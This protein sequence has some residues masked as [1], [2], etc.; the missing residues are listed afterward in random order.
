[1]S[2]RFRL[3]RSSA[4]LALLAPPLVLFLL[5]FVAPLLSLFWASLHTASDNELYGPALTT[6]HYATILTDPF[7][8]TIILRTLGTGAVILLLCLVLGYATAYVLAPLPPQRRLLLL[9][10]LVLPLMVSNVVRAYGW[11]AILG[12]QGLVN[13]LLRNTGVI[14]RP[15]VLLNSFE[16]VSFGLMTILLP[17]MVISVTNTLTAIDAQ[18]KEA[19]QSLRASPVRTFIHVTWPLSSPGV[20][21]GMLLVF[22]LTLSAYVTIT[23]LGGPRMK[24]LVSLV[25]DQVGAFRWP[26][27]AALA[28]VL[29]GLALAAGGLI[30]A[31]LRPQR[32]QGKG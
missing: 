10:L 28:F 12:R 17:Y 6:A 11:I 23:L 22:L 18:Y 8:H 5:F 31:I 25:F 26:L 19:A 29:L 2:R 24:L 9:A 27:A 7:Y 4:G 1:M 13:S 30:L 14:E 20:A 21:S 32:V 3:T 15:L 16:A